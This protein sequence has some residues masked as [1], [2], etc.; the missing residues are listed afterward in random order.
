MGGLRYVTGY[1]DLPPTRLNVSIGDT[2][3]GLYG[4]I[5]ALMGLLARERGSISRGES[6]D[7]GLYEA[8]FSVMES[9]VPEYSAYGQIRERT[10][11][12]I[13]GVAPSGTYPC[14]DG[15]WVV[16]GGNADGI[17]KRFMTAI[18][19]ADLATDPALSDNRG[20]AAQGA[21]LDAVITGWT[22][23]RSVAEVME[24]LVAAGVP[25]GPIYSVAD[26]VDDPHFRARDM[27]V[28]GDVRVEGEE[29]RVTFPGIVPKLELT[30]G[31]VRWFG[32]ELGEHTYDVL[33]EL[34]RP[35]RGGHRL[36]S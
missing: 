8:V 11:N 24:V 29:E 13:S 30:P 32:P 31:A 27:L 16:I 17:Y 36:P 7:I 26:M 6:I 25:S 35:V 4:A 22:L 20:R 21:M 18:G 34:L 23:A 15:G 2:L 5:G 12:S 1:P 19:R 33:S 10:G 14:Q 3:A 9:V 28:D